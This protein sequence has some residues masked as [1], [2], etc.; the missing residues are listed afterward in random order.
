MVDTK[1]SSDKGL[2]VGD[3]TMTAL[4]KP[5]ARLYVSRLVQND[6]KAIPPDAAA[7]IANAFLARL[8]RR[9]QDVRKKQGKKDVPQSNLETVT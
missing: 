9:L 7:K 4:R 3:P 5:D 8:S 1:E 6:D 2:A